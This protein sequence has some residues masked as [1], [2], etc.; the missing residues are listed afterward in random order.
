MGKIKHERTTEDYF[1]MVRRIIRA[2]GRRA[3]ADENG[4]E[5]LA[6]MET[7]L[8]NAIRQAVAGCRADGYSWAEVGRIFGITRQA[9]WERFRGEGEAT[10]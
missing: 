1:A 10:A 2:A 8:D 9:A 5:F 6:G 7:E 4:L 3:A